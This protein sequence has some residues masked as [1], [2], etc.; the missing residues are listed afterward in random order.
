[1]TQA[2]QPGPHDPYWYEAVVGLRY[3]VDLIDPEANVA[4]VTFQKPAVEG[5]DDVVVSHADG[6]RTGIQVKHTRVETPLTFNDLVRHSDGGASLL[7]KMSR[8]WKTLSEDCFDCTTQLFSN[9]PLADEERSR[10]QSALTSFLTAMN[11]AVSD[12]DRFE[13][14]TVPAEHEAA[15][16]TWIAELDHLNHDEKLR[17]LQNLQ[18]Q[19][20]RPD[21]ASLERE[22]IERLTAIF[23]GIHPSTA[24]QIYAQLVRKLM[25][26]TTSRRGTSVEVRAEEVLAAIG[27]PNEETVGDHEFP[28]PAPFFPSRIDFAESLARSLRE[29]SAITF[30]TGPAGAGKTSIVSSLAN[31]VDPAIDLRFYAFRPISP[32]SSMLPQDYSQ[33]AAASALWGDLLV[34]LRQRF[35]VGRLSEAKVPVRNDLLS[36]DPGRLRDHVLRLAALLATERGQPTVIAIDGLDHAA[37]ARAI[38][39]FSLLDWLVPPSK[40]PEGVRFLIAGQPQFDRYP[41]WLRNRDEVT[42]V[43]VPPIAPADIEALLRSDLGRFPEDQI[44]RAA[45][46][47]SKQSA[48][49]TL[50]AVYAVA[51][52]RMVNDGLELESVLETRQLHDG[53][54]AYYDRIWNEALRPLDATAPAAALRLAAAL[55]FSSAR[56]TGPLLHGFYSDTPFVPADWEQLLRKLAPIVDEQGGSFA[57]MHND[58]RLFLT[59]KLRANPE[60]HAAAAWHIA[61][62]YMNAPSSA[63]KYADLIRALTLANRRREIPPVFTPEYVVEAWTVE[64]S[65]PELLSD[66]RQAVTSVTSDTGWDT[67]HRLALGLRTLQQLRSA[68]QWIDDPGPPA[69]VPACL[70]SEARPAPPPGWT[71]AAVGGVLVDA[72]RLT[73]EGE[74]ARARALMRRWFDGLTPVDVVEELR[75]HPGDLNP[76]ERRDLDETIHGL[77]RTW[78]GLA[79]DI[80]MPRSYFRQKLDGEAGT[81]MAHFYG[82]WL[83]AGVTGSRPWDVALRSSRIWFYRD[84]AAVTQE[85]AEEERWNE[86]TF[87]LRYVTDDRENFPARFR[88]MAAPWSLRTG[89]DRLIGA[90]AQPIADRGF[91][92]AQT[93]SKFPENDVE[94]YEAIAF[95]LGWFEV[96]RPATSISGEGADAYFEQHN[97]ETGLTAL[98]RYL[99]AIATVGRL[100]RDF[101]RNP[102]DLGGLVRPSEIR[103]VIEGLF[104][105]DSDRGLNVTPFVS[106]RGPRLLH[107]ILD[108]V[109]AQRDQAYID[110]VVP[111]VLERAKELPYDPYLEVLWKASAERGLHDLL[112]Q[113]T[114]RWIGPEGEAWMMDLAER[115][116]A[117]QEFARLAQNVG[118]GEL[119]SAAEIRSKRMQ[120]GYIGRKEYALA[121]PLRWFEMATVDDPSIW[122]AEGMRLLS[123]SQVASHGGDN[124]EAVYVESAVTVAAARSGP[125]ALWRCLTALASEDENP[126]ALARTSAIDGIIGMLEG[127]SLSSTELTSLW[128]IGFGSLVWQYDRHRLF[129]QHLRQA[130]VEVAKQRQDEERPV[131]LAALAPRC[132]EITGNEQL[133]RYPNRWFTTSEGTAPPPYL[134]SAAALISEVRERSLE[135]SVEHLE[136]IAPEILKDTGDPG[137]LWR[138]IADTATRLGEERPANF[139]NL[140]DRL[141]EITRGRKYAY[142]WYFDGVQNAFAALIPLMDEARRW[143]LCAWMLEVSMTDKAADYWIE[144]VAANLSSLCGARAAAATKVDR[145]NGLEQE[146]SAQETWILGPEREGE[147]HW[148]LFIPPVS[149]GS[150]PATWGALGIHGLVQIMGA[151]SGAERVHAAMEGLYALCS[152]APTLAAEVVREFESLPDERRELLLLIGE[153]LVVSV[154]ESAAHLHPLFEKVA[155]TGQGRQRLQSL[156]CL[157]ASERAGNKVPPV[158]LEPAKGTHSHPPLAAGFID[159]GPE[160]F[161]GISLT[162]GPSAVRQSVQQ[163]A[164]A[165][166]LD[167]TTLERAAAGVVRDIASPPESSTER[168]L[169]G[170]MLMRPSTALE[171][172]ASWAVDEAAAGCFGSVDT[173]PLAQA[174]L[175]MDDPWV[176]TH[177]TASLIGSADWPVDDELER[178]FDRGEGAIV[179]ALSQQA[180]L[181]LADDERVL[182]SVLQTFSR[183]RDVILHLETRWL[184]DTADL[185]GVRRPSTFNG[186]TFTYYDIDAFEPEQAE[187]SGW[188]TFRTGG[189]GLL[190]YGRVP[191]TPAVRIWRSFGWE[192]SVRTPFVWEC[193]G[194]PVGRFEMWYG[195]FR[196]SLQDRLY[197]QPLLSRWI[198]SGTAWQGAERV[199]GAT[200]RTVPDLSVYDRPATSP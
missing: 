137:D 65:M 58:V 49:N 127:A 23:G 28:P 110:A 54:D 8:G 38:G 156:I 94:L 146:L 93:E 7:R 88:I 36:N 184:R 6:R 4:G 120:V 86:V 32:K 77:V 128:C 48:G 134:R 2:L 189:Q 20:G 76:A 25:T 139:L 64:R 89:D 108:I 195:P 200:L 11:D 5:L 33:T 19:G 68:L 169:E 187:N 71:L 117:V 29:G 30:L 107:R 145:L 82:G 119:A 174:L 60:A 124:R 172:F 105:P 144:S 74:I 155:R 197:R 113:W 31:R 34:Q 40:V 188:L 176:L 153:R 168:T 178:L 101:A 79:Q 22:I 150:T 131:K 81:I 103:S 185:R 133:F 14:I 62:Y 141:T 87:T 42:V 46:I 84:I 66:A 15:W 177:P 61:D 136:Y 17:F 130:L 129:L 70:P 9:R 140:L 83:R 118:L 18:I 3:V 122:E 142:P 43:E 27:V 12:V 167:E 91:T 186:R 21:R 111:I 166:E 106:R 50:A 165:L 51:E 179:E 78:G 80:G 96:S 39:Q 63:A 72:T 148:P 182:G 152:E 37:R 109:T 126:L 191:L 116:E 35:F 97:Y 132:F 112:E 192:P 175:N 135:G 26:W 73:R 53:V 41:P 143:E 125:A 98:R 149:D 183:D 115:T 181:G 45:A 59:A 16:A 99:Y 24:E 104:A 160:M 157:E 180:R 90:W 171:A 121:V 194:V 170:G 102:S 154:A 190:L 173:L 1:M 95:T 164:A 55:A 13:E 85:L 158:V 75:R 123:I 161:G 56:L 196:N 199:L 69:P 52:A 193:R 163:L 57:A 198:I 114:K 138:A 10:S 44:D 159:G 151:A 162:R 67:L 92:A 147:T 100:E 47:I